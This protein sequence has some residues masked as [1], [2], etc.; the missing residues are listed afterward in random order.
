MK[1]QTFVQYR[2][3]SLDGDVIDVFDTWEDV[4]DW[5]QRNGKEHPDWQIT[6]YKIKQV[7]TTET[8]LN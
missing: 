3:L 7:V 6:R 5:Q 1:T 8:F 2:I 4:E